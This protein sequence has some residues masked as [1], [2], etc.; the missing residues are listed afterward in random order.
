LAEI[1]FKGFAGLSNSV[2]SS[3]YRLALLCGA[4]S[5]A[6]EVPLFVRVEAGEGLL[7]ARV[8]GVLLA[9][10]EAGEGLLLARVEGVLLTRAKS[11]AFS[12]SRLNR[13]KF[14][15]SLLTSNINSQI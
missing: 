14:L 5:E 10:V 2:S 6:G 9:R 11:P 8:E 1:P 12:N 7:L 15:M 3:L 13:L 4:L